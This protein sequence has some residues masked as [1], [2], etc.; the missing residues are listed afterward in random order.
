MKQIIL[1]DKQ[2]HDLAHA[3]CEAVYAQCVEREDY[4]DCEG[5]YADDCLQIPCENGYAYVAASGST[6]AYEDNRIF[7]CNLT[8]DVVFLD[9]E[10]NDDELFLAETQVDR[11]NELITKQSKEL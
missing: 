2:L 7:V 5:H 1:T 11:L 4:I 8:D 6:T 9:I 10:N 3:V